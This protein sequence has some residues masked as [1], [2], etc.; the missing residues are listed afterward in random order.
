[1]EK[2]G[3]EFDDELV[4][5]AEKLGEYRCPKCGVKLGNS[6]PPTYCPNCGTEP[7]EKRPEV[8]ESDGS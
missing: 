1:M 2:Y 5:Q 7:F 3:V 4:K 6:Q 8:R